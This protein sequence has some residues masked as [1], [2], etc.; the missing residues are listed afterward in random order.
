MISEPH[1]L[2]SRRGPLAVLTLNRPDDR[3]PLDP[4]LSQALLDELRA[5][6]ADDEVRAVAIGANGSAFCAGGDL[7][8][9][10]ELARRPAE[11]AWAWPRAIVD[12]HQLALRAPKPLVALVDGPAYAGG[13]G[14]AGICDIVLAT[15]R[16]SFALPE[17]R[18]GLFPMIIVAHLARLLPRR[19]LLDMMLTGRAIDVD[20]AARAGFLSRVCANPAEMWA[21]ADEYAGMFTDTSP[22]AVALG[23]RAFALLAE[24]PASQSLEAAQ[25]LNLTFFLG[26]DLAEGASAFLDKRPPAWRSGEDRSEDG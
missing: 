26:S 13:M 16:A 20:E 10:K 22:T 25:F 19:L 11:E 8:Q 24:M 12:L 14:L 7:R 5:A 9:L 21:A 6:L 18:V 3:N 4:E 23:R 17:V 1:V 15:R 2:V